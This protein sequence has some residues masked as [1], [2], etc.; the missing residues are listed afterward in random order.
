[1]FAEVILDVSCSY[2]RNFISSADHDLLLIVLTQ[3]CVIISAISNETEV[4]EPAQTCPADGTC[5]YNM[6]AEHYLKRNN[7]ETLQFCHKTT[8][9]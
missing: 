9:Q 6:T 7:Q 8:Q 4:P 3:A 1:L 2:Q 5:E